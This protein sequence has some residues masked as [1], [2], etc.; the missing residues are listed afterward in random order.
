MLSVDRTDEPAPACLSDERSAPARSALLEL[1]TGNRETIAQTRVRFEGL[2]VDGPELGEA[3]GRLFRNRCAFCETQT[4]TWPYRFRPT[5]EAGPSGQAPGQDEYRSHLYYTWLTNA[6]RNIY[7][8]CEGCRPT[9][10]SLFPV[11]RKRTPLPTED[12]IRL[13][14]ERPAGDWRGEIAESPV[15][16]A[17]AG[18]EDLRKHFAPLPDGILMPTDQRGEATVRHFNLNRPPLVEARRRAL[19][20]YFRRLLLARQRP[21]FDKIMDFAGLDFGGGW[22]LHLYQ[23][24]RILGHGGGDRQVLS[25][26]RIAAY[27]RDRAKRR[28]FQQRLQN[29]R[30]EL[31]R[32]PEQIRRAKL[33]PSLAPAGTARPVRVA[34]RNFKAI[35]ELT[36]ELPETSGRISSEGEPLAPCLIILGENAAGKSSIL[37]AAALAISD[38]EVRADEAPLASGF[39]LDPMLMGAEG[40]SRPRPGSVTVDYDDGLQTKLAFDNNGFQ[41]S[42]TLANVE[43]R[44]PVFAYGA[45]RMFLGHDEASASGVIRSLFEP[46]YVLVNP[47]EWLAEIRETPLFEEVIRALRYILGIGQ[48]FDTIKVDEKTKRCVLVIKVERPGQTP[49][50]T[51]TP[52]ATVSSGFR[53]VLGMACDVMRNLV[54][55]QNRFSATLAKSRAV[56]LVDE[57]EAHLHPRW[58]LKIM[59]GLRDALPNVTFIVTTHDPLCLRGMDGGEV[60]VL[61]RAA[62]AFCAPDEPPTF[63]DQLEDLPPIGALTVEQLLTSDL[64]QLFTTDADTIETGLAGVGDLLARE[65]ARRLEPGDDARLQKVRDQIGKDVAVSLPIGS[66]EVQRLVQEAVEQYLRERLRRPGGGLMALREETR[67]AIVDALKAL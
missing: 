33:R 25:R 27:F 36:L 37:E 16:V 53:A 15:F 32:D 5:E 6:W 19:D 64:F 47:E 62:K 29:A 18:R 12:A 14:V 59:Q 51:R 24:A 34:L 20:D 42:F 4:T 28:D 40:Q 3:L 1:F 60:K 23:L 45:Y 21:D 26:Q 30:D 49:I 44:I 13:Y 38:E 67:R 39:M 55:R 48:A 17:P 52:L 9:E 7:P 31:A 61:L 2:A 10:P 56:V 35:E 63:V 11:N 41:S 46:D 57:I 22:F 43:P 8:I 58:K 66:T 50:F 54:A 65:Q